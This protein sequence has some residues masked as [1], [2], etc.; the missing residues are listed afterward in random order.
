MRR[1]A[2]QKRTID[3]FMLICCLRSLYATRLG[4]RSAIVYRGTEQLAGAVTLMYRPTRRSG[5]SAV[6]VN[7]AAY[8]TPPVR[9]YDGLRAIKNQRRRVAAGRRSNAGTHKDHKT[10]TGDGGARRFDYQTNY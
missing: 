6:P 5:G 1:P 10:N 7:G 4:V 3:E 2:S 9:L 8:A